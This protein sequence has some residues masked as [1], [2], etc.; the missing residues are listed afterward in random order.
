MSDFLQAVEFA[1]DLICMM[2][3]LNLSET[4]RVPP[5]V[6][7]A[8]TMGALFFLVASL[9]VQNARE[10][11]AGSAATGTIIGICTAVIGFLGMGQP[12]LRGIIVAGYVPLVIVLRLGEG[13]ILG[14][15]YR[16]AAWFW[17]LLAL[18][19][20]VVG[21][22]V[23]IHAVPSASLQI[24]KAVW[25]IS[26]AALASYGWATIVCA[27]GSSFFDSPMAKMAL[28]IVFASTVLYVQNFPFEQFLF[29]WVFPLGFFLGLIGTRWR[30]GGPTTPKGPKTIA[31]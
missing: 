20:P 25:C 9:L 22:S 8:F 21:L 2:P 18:L 10:T 26:G 4:I 11:F 15:R 5:E 6:C 13:A 3:P 23:A 7:M 19:P 29:Q 12:L 30:A 28:F 31:P 14:S 27:N 16:S 24:A 17:R 1:E